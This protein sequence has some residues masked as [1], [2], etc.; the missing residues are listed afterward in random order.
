MIKFPPVKWTCKQCGGLKYIGNEFY[1]L[2]EYWVDV[3]CIKCGHSV[4]IQVNRLN[5]LIEKLERMKK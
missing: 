4:D 1:M 3:T 5:R 2:S